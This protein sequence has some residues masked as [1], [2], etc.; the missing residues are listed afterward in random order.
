[1]ATKTATKKVRVTAKQVAE[2]RKKAV[3]DTTPDWTGCET[4]TA[5]QFN[6]FFRHSMDYYRLEADNKS[7]KPTVIRWMQRVGASAE[8]IASVK[9]LK[10]NRFNSTMGGVAGCLLRGMPDVREDFNGGRNTAE[11]L[12]KSISEAITTGKADIEVEET[13]EAAPVTIQPSIQ[14]RLRET[15]GRMTEEIEEAL[16][17]FHNDAENF[18]PKAF[19][20]I[21]L[22]RGKGVKSAHARIIKSFYERDL[23][24][25]LELASGNADEQLR[26]GYSHRS[27][28]QI[29]KLIEFYQE[30][31][32]ACDMLG[33]EAKVNRKPRAKKP[34]DKAKVVAKLKYKK[35]DDALKLVSINPIDIIGSKELWIYNTKT[36]KLGKYVAAEFNELG[37]K[38]ASITGFDEI[39][40]VQKTLRKPA[41]QLKAFKDAGKVALR[42]FLEEINAVDS[43]MN[44]R[45]NEETVLLKIQ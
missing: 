45:I 39:K 16:E 34:A 32:S 3:K 36:R 29:R 8:D 28:K 7:F 10:D 2:H 31:M 18:D 37:V 38:G 19:K 27:R 17:S 33:Q 11:W 15:A 6:S 40:S 9:K 43:K 13:K 23:N 24:E 35:Q 4:W 14:D 30:I 12:L 5:D 44:G 26:E 42:K 21:N 22:F 1:M 41:E 20:I 25:L